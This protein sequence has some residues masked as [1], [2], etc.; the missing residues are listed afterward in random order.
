VGHA[1]VRAEYADDI[2]DIVA[3]YAKYNGRRKPEQLEP[4]T[5]SLVNYN[6]AA[7]IV[8]EYKALAARAEKIS[9]ALPRPARCLLPA[10]AVSGEGQRGG[11]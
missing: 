4:N 11:E 3:K 7:R 1:R 9:A 6:E 8:D 5:Y 10:G 2:A